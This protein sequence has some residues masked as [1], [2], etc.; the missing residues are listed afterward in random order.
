MSQPLVQ[1]LR[2]V[3]S[4]QPLHTRK[5]HL[6]ENRSWWASVCSA[7]GSH[8]L[9]HASER[10]AAGDDGHLARLDLCN[11]SA[12][13]GNLSGGD[14]RWNI[15]RQTLDDSIGKFGALRSRKLFYLFQNAGNGLSHGIR[16]QPVQMRASEQKRKGRR[17]KLPFAP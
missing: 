1:R 14:V 9:P 13:R 5:A 17:K 7:R 4:W 10:L 12:H 16:I 11:A 3:N 15:V 2:G 8:K 6:G